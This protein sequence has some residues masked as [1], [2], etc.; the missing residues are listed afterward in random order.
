METKK[1]RIIGKKIISRRNAADITYTDSEYRQI[2]FQFCAP[3]SKFYGKCYKTIGVCN[4]QCSRSGYTGS[5]YHWGIANV[6]V[7]RFKKGY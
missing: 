2:H 5:Y 3:S 6:R 7:I 4:R 1:R